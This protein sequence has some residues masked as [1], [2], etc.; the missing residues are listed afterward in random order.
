MEIGFFCSS[1]CP[2][3]SVTASEMATEKR[4]DGL[5]SNMHRSHA[6]DTHSITQ[7]THRTSHTHHT[8]D[9]GRCSGQRTFT[10]ERPTRTR[11]S[12]VSAKVLFP[13]ALVFLLFLTAIPPCF[14]GRLFPQPP[15]SDLSICHNRDVIRSSLPSPGHPLSVKPMSPRATMSPARQS[16]V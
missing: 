6:A 11:L 3:V 13:D 7:D 15:V 1:L 8:L 9:S 12:S 5:A 2:N 4:T 16:R 10:S 14:L